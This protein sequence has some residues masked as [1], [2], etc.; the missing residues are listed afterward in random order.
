M[1]Q[2]SDHLY[3][4]SLGIVNVFLLEGDNGHT[5]IDTGVPGSADKVLAAIRKGGK[6]PE[7]I[8]H[9]VLTHWHPDHAGSAAELRQRLGARVYAHAADS[10]ILAQGGGPRPRYLTPGLVNWLAFRLFINGMS[11]HI[12]PVAVDEQV[13]DGQVLPLGPGMQVVHT[14]G[15]SAGHMALLLTSEGVL[16]AGDLCANAAGLDYSIVYE[17]LAEGRQS[18]LK[19]A[20]LP[21]DQAVFGHGNALKTKAAQRL[22]ETFEKPLPASWKLKAV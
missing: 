10:D 3:Q 12:P 11:P 15:H 9:I 20:A 4:V 17:D 16:V 5:L 6:N 21:F 7:D 14:P 22:R 13:T 1:K 2:I 19:A 8:R 18:I